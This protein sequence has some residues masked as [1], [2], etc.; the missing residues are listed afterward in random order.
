MQ[1]GTQLLAPDGFHHLEKGITYSLLKNDSKRNRVLLLVFSE[2][3]PAVE[4]VEIN[5]RFFEDGC[6]GK[7]IVEKENQ[8]TMPPWLKSY[9]ELSL[10]AIERNRKYQAKKTYREVVND[11]FDA[12]A[13]LIENVDAVLSA[14]DPCVMINKHAAKNRKNETRIRLWFFTYLAFGEKLEVLLPQKVE[15]WN[16]DEKL[17]TKKL[18]RKSSVTGGESGFRVTQEMKKLIID[19]FAK[20]AILGRKIGD[21]YAEAMVRF[22]KCKVTVDQNG[23]KR[24]IYG[25]KPY[26]TYDQYTYHL[27]KEIG[28]EAVHIKIYGE[29]RVRRTKGSSEGRFSE[30]VSN[31][32]E[33]I[34]S[35]GYYCKDRP[36]GFLEG[37]VLPPLVVVRIVCHVS[38]LV[39]GIGFSFG[40]ETHIAY[41]LALFCMAVPKEFFC[42]LFGMKI[43]KEQWP[44]HGRSPHLI[45]DKGPGAKLDIIPDGPYR[46]AIK[47]LPPSYSGQSKATSE[48]SHPRDT[49]TEGEPVYIASDLNPVQMARREIKRVLVDNS[50]SDADNRRTPEMIADN[51]FPNP[52]G[53]WNFLDQRGRTCA[54]PISIQDAVRT[55]LTPIK[56]TVQH[57]GLYYR[58]QR[59]D[60]RSLRETGLIER[61]SRGQNADCN[62]YM[63]DCCLRYLWAEIDGKIILLAAKLPIRDSEEQLFMSSVE[64]ETMEEQRNKQKPMFRIHKL[65]TKAEAYL[66]FERLTG[67][68]WH[69]GSQKKG[70][71]GK[72]GALQQREANEAK[73]ILSPKK[74]A[75]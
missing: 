58:T 64:L 17:N 52:I 11:R 21:I 4:L 42:S 8:A 2:G 7:L 14:E 67:K 12:I 74:K 13:A 46:F 51:V 36:R 62:G 44:N 25:G 40:S 43:K 35:D 70:S 9:E 27:Y 26:P 10:T 55:Y 29:V 71:P 32:L 16:R 31:L 59:F 73:S 75:S 68:K 39:L 65:A 53:V 57:D 49:K 41:R 18:G 30:R 3:K 56:L 47:G 15:T 48:S 50:C 20:L 45:T 1:I 6:V 72:G 54:L 24:F 23:G 66:E 22:F 60:S 19:S 61:V 28:K 38:G 5:R 63:L 34:E 69:S 37:S 33:I